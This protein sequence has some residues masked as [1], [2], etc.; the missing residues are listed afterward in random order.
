MSGSQTEAKRALLAKL[1]K[2][3]AATNQDAP[4]A[5]PELRSLPRDQDLPLSF[6]QERVWFLDKLQPE[7]AF[8]N[9]LDLISFSGRLN[10]ETL[11]RCL[12]L[13]VA[14][15]E[16]L[17]STFPEVDGL[18]VQ[19]VGPPYRVPLPV[20]DLRALSPEERS[21]QWHEIAAREAKT[22]F[23]LATGPLLRARLLRLQDDEHLLVFTVHHIAWDGWSLGLFLQ[24]LTTAY[25]ALAGGK[26]PELPAL[27]LQYVD[28]ADW[29]RRWL[30]G[31]TLEA[32]RQF[33]GQRLGGNLPTLDLPLDRPRMPSRSFEA[34]PLDVNVEGDLLTAIRE[35]SRREGMTLYTTVLTLFNI[36]LNRY[37]GQED[38]LIGTLVAGRVRPEIEQAIGCF[39][40]TIALRT[41]LSGDPTF[42]EALRRTRDVIL[43]AHA[44]ADY[45]YEE[46]IKQ[47]QPHRDLNRNPVLQVFLNMLNVRMWDD[48]VL[49]GLTIR[50]L[51]ALEVHA[52]A[53]GLTL[54]ASEAD[55]RLQLC[56]GY[57]TELF[58]TDTI[59]RMAGHLLTLMADAAAH[60]ELCI[61]RLRM[62]SPSEEA[63]LLR[64][65]GEGARPVAAETTLHA[66]FEA[67]VARDPDATALTFE[68]ITLS[69]G[70]LNARANRVAGSLRDLGVGPD[71]LVGL[72]AERSLDLVIGILGILKAGGAYLPLD[73]AYPADR[74]GFMIQDAA[75]SVIL[76]Q[77]TIAPLLPAS[78]AR[79]V[80]LD[81]AAASGPES[82][83][84]PFSRAGPSNLAY[85]IYTSGSTG[86]PK[87]VLITHAN[88]VRLL[89]ATRDWFHF[90]SSDVWTLFHSFGFDFSVW[91]IWGA[92]AYGGRLVIV[93]R[94]TTRD[95]VA[96]RRLLA[97]ERVTVLNQTPSAFG[98][99]IQ[100]DEAEATSDLGLRFVI[101]GGEALDLAPLRPWVD[102][103]GDAAPRL[104]NMYGITETCVHVTYRRITRDDIR[105]NQA[106]P[107]GMPI[108]DL[109]VYLL[110]QRDRLVPFGLPGEIHVAGPG[111]ARGYLNRPELTEERFVPDPFRAGERM[112]RSGDLARRRPDGELEYLGRRDRQVKIRGHRI[113]LGEIEATLLQVPGIRAAVVRPQP[114][115]G[116]ADRLVAYVVPADPSATPTSEL[117]RGALRRTLPEYMLPDSVIAL[118]AL[119]LTANGKIDR[120]ALPEPPTQTASP[121]SSATPTTENEQIVARIW[122]EVLGL[123]RIGV[124]DNFFELG[125]HSL[126][127]ARVTARLREAFRREVPVRRLFE[128]QT[129]AELAKSFDS[130]G[131]EVAL[132]P[133][134]M[135]E[136]GPPVLSFAQERLWFFEQLEPG[137]SAYNI[138]MILRFRGRLDTGALERSLSTIL[139]RHEVLRSTFSS[140]DGKP[141][142]V[143]GPPQ[144]WTVQTCGLDGIAP[145]LRETEG[146]KLAHSETLRPFDLQTG[147]LV[148]ALLI[149][150]GEGGALLRSHASSHRRRRVVYPDPVERIRGTLPGRASST[151]RRPFRRSRSSIT[152]SP[153]LSGSS[154]PPTGYGKIWNTG[155][156][157][158]MAPPP[159]W[160]SP[161]IEPRPAQQTFEGAIH[162]SV[163]GAGLLQRLHE[164]SRAEDATLFMTLLAG[165][166]VLLSRLSGQNDLCVGSR[167]QAAT[168][169][170]RR[171]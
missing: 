101:F 39:V 140:D 18:P 94:D 119:P 77:R 34:R 141:V 41:D 49:P 52:V 21:R 13:V 121:G 146:L 79:I 100:A 98:Q 61:S 104:I 110:D 83:G 95:P 126:L 19:R 145:E 55:D 16:V 86:R 149:Q 7:S 20:T 154:F 137:S 144:P 28:F 22:L 56:F 73:P 114:A 4:A 51:S 59:E 87:G 143:I 90:D 117:I 5:Q 152:I 163:L 53:D 147:P 6:G 37:T 139:A 108:P 89:A 74:L 167:S 131:P 69:Y 54:F 76:T 103:H 171:T 92:L 142:L 166:Q 96:F 60:P 132:D 161:S 1:L 11:N 93:P 169:S 78:S 23:D 134:M 159:R 17:R 36:L 12:D 123:E 14:R 109:R 43:S 9:H 35:L 107:I 2:E 8:Y 57:P 120:N 91:E 47:L 106:S 62:V 156:G 105:R 118:A 85:V 168:E 48:I 44:H 122:C 133:A 82:P 31:K 65:G 66:L 148:R 84:G 68:D 170:K 50:S 138:P 97:R 29:Q 80:L 64:A 155:S 67:Q 157:S 38:V 158:S 128:L 3:R 45:P 58:D 15:H 42:R 27:P 130:G 81:E 112:Y 115:N 30:S 63:T 165:F 24:E 10:V 151:G 33:W 32:Q 70:E 102:R 26:T 25:P 129:V 136:G 153:M 127:A 75:L 125:G 116:V 111:L 135:L 46:L 150:L 88:V 113:E 164:V 71:H 162:S 99:L 160:I 40:N 124:N 72:C